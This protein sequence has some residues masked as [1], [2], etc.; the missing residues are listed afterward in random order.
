MAGSRRLHYPRQQN[1][2]VGD[3]ARAGKVL[4]DIRIG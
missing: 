1:D 2:M 4:V 3:G